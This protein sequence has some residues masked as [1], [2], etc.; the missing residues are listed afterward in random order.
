MMAVSRMLP[1]PDDSSGDQLKTG[2][3]IAPPERWVP[4][5][6]TALTNRAAAANNEA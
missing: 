6:V 3:E 2:R 4:P 5:I 1:R